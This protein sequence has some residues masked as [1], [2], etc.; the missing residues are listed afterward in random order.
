MRRSESKVLASHR[1][2]LTRWA[3][4]THAREAPALLVYRYYGSRCNAEQRRARVAVEADQLLHTHTHVN[5]GERMK[6]SLG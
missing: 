5:E 6:P 4:V 3:R 2:A 1:H